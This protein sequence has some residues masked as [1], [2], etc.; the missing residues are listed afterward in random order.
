MARNN[1]LADGVQAVANEMRAKAADYLRNAKSYSCRSNAELRA[2]LV[3]GSAVLNM[4]ANMVEKLLDETGKTATKSP[5][6]RQPASVAEVASEPEAAD[7][8]LATEAQ[9]QDQDAGS[10][11]VSPVWTDDDPS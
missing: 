9:Q 3:K 4:C 10:M 2:G 11:D 8:Q 6:P 7:G 1:K 5:T